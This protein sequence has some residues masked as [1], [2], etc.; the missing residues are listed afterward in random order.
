MGISSCFY[1]AA[2][3]VWF[4][5]SVVGPRLAHNTWV[6]VYRQLFVLVGAFGRWFFPRWTRVALYAP[7]FHGVVLPGTVPWE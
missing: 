4:V 1:P 3:G 6:M 5:D 7:L 2:F